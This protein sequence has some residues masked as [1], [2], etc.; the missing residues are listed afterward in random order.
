MIKGIFFDIDGT[1]F[2][3]TMG[4]VPPSTLEALEKLREK[5]ILC[6]MATG[7]HIS[8]LR[9]MAVMALPF[10]GYVTLN[11]QL[12]YDKDQ[13]LF[14]GCPFMEED[15]QALA[16]A[17][18]QNELPLMI[19]EQDDLYI[20][21]VDDMV[22]RSLGDVSTPSPKA[23][24][25]QGEPIY[26]GMVFGPLDTVK[27]F[28]QRLPHCK[29]TWWNSY[30]ADIIPKNGG[31]V[32]GIRQALSHFGLKKEETMAFGDGEN[33]M[34]M[35]SFVEIGVAMGNAQQKVKDCAHYVTAH[36]DDDGIYRALQHFSIL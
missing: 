11:G 7:R 1:L 32:A 3:H 12:C 8:E 27:Q 29:P 14:Y 2:S 13:Q 22:R 23:G 15:A 21:Y 35:L 16:E 30:G 34:E 25:Y 9:N 31:K 33:D 10:D 18:A 5:G 26:Q 24:T 28:C 36:I 6:F 19:V 17:F 4:C 20:N